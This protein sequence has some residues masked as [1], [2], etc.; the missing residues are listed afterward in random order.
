MSTTQGG[1]YDLRHYRRPGSCGA[2]RELPMEREWIL[3]DFALS[4]LRNTYGRPVRSLV[5]P[6]VLTA[7]GCLPTIGKASAVN[8]DQL[9]AKL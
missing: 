9:I 4:A 2:K 1:L 6:E 8:P 7:S 5:P 3:V